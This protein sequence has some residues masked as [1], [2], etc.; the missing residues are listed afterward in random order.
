[1]LFDK[2]GALMLFDNTRWLI[3]VSSLTIIAIPPAIATTLTCGGDT[4]RLT[5]ASGC[6]NVALA[7]IDTLGTFTVKFT[8][9]F[10][11]VCVAHAMAET[12]GV[13]TVNVIPLSGCG[14]DADASALMFG[15]DTV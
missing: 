14:K 13:L 1:M 3:F 10:H 6:G 15:T 11:P 8:S 12:L 5:V 9:A 7:D 4:A 2:I